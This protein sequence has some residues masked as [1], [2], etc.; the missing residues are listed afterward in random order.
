MQFEELRRVSRTEQYHQGVERQLEEEADF[1]QKAPVG[2][3]LSARRPL[4]ADSLAHQGSSSFP[5]NGR[6][7]P[8]LLTMKWWLST[9]LETAATAAVPGQ[10][11]RAHRGRAAGA[12]VQQPFFLCIRALRVIGTAQEDHVLRRPPVV[13][14]FRVN[15]AHRGRCGT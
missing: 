13:T 14:G 11:R 15:L 9:C 6:K 3:A 12:K 2:L 4:Q 8:R 1:V 7:I 10:V 5:H